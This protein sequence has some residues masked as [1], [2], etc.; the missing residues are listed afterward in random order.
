MSHTCLYHEP[1]IS[2]SST[3]PMAL[4]DP[5]SWYTHG[6]S[7]SCHAAGWLE[8]ST[9]PWC[10]AARTPGPN[11][12]RDTQVTSTTRRTDP[13]TQTQL[14]GMLFPQQEWVFHSM[15]LC[16]SAQYTPSVAPDPRR[17]SASHCYVLLW[18][19][20]Q[21]PDGKKTVAAIWAHYRNLS[22]CTQGS[23]AWKWLWVCTAPALALNPL[24]KPLLWPLWAGCGY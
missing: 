20:M 12:N 21:E 14:H 23:A 9:A 19:T 22:P 7:S 6:F 5:G 2:H 3:S 4:S 24:S 10:S 8:Q 15:S 11:P 13:C 16:R 1:L 18:E 17:V